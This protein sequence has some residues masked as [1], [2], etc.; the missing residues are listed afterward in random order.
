[1]RIYK[2]VIRSTLIYSVET[3]GDIIKKEQQTEVSERQV[4]ERKAISIRRARERERGSS[5]FGGDVS[6]QHS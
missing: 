6:G 4:F 1:M 5:T 3:N 2:S